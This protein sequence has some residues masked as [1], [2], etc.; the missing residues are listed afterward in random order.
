MQVHRVMYLHQEDT[1]QN[2]KTMT[3]WSIER[4]CDSECDPETSN[5]CVEMG[6]RTKVVYCTSCCRESKCNV[7]SKA[8]SSVPTDMRIFYQL[9]FIIG[10]YII[11][12]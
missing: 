9:S 3:P 11:S 4:G 6:A 7:D 1:N 10:L 2:N 8:P 5:F 12:T